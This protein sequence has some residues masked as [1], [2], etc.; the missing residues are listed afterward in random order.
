MTFITTPDIRGEAAWMVR[1]KLIPEGGTIL[2]PPALQ[3]TV[4]RRD[5]WQLHLRED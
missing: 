1:Q 5:D 4:P 2:R 3:T